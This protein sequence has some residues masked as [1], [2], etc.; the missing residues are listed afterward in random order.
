[1]THKVQAFPSLVSAAASKSIRSAS[2]SLFNKVGGLG[3]KE[4]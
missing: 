2:A 3:I 1:M 4:V